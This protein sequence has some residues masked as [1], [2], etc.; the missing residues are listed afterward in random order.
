MAGGVGGDWGE[1]YI[2][3]HNKILPYFS[4]ALMHFCTALGLVKISAEVRKS[5]LVPWALMHFCTRL[6]LGLGL[7]FRLGLGLGL[8]LRCE[9]ALVPLSPPKNNQPLFF[10][11]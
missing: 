3:K 1:W 6:G 11:T 4:P 2:L 9:S 7:G 5:A 8:V 10:F